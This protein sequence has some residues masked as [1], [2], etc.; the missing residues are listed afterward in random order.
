MLKM[1]NIFIGALILSI[2][3]TTLFWGKDIGLSMLLFNVPL[4]WYLIYILEKNNKIENKKAKLL[5]IPIILLS[6]TYLIFNNTFFNTINVLLIPL[7]VLI[8]VMWLYNEDFSIKTIIGKMIQRVLDP[9]AYAGETIGKMRDSIKQRLNMKIDKEKKSRAGKIFTALCIT[10]PL[11]TVVI[12]LLSSADEAFGKMFSDI[13]SSIGDFFAN[14]QISSFVFRIIV[15]ILL[16]I[17]IASFFD[18]IISKYKVQKTEIQ[19][20][21][22]KDNTT[23]KMVLGVLNVIYLLFCIVQI[24]SLLLKDIDNYSEYAR[25]GFFQLMAVSLINLVTILISKR[26]ENKEDIKSS[27]YINI[28]C[29]IMVLFTFVIIVSS[30][31]RMFFYESAYGYTFLR[32]LVY[33]VLITE[34]ILLIPTCYFILDKKVQLAKV[35]F[36]IIMTMYVCMNFANFDNI[37]AKRNVDRY[38]ET[39]KIDMM[40]LMEDTGTDAVRQIKRLT[41]ANIGEN[42]DEDQKMA[43]DYLTQMYKDLENK[44]MDFRD[45]NISKALAK[46]LIERVNI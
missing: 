18:N 37:I 45:F 35:Y 32:L 44:K 29:I 21:K 33:C 46:Y 6:S 19:E 30:A 11:A 5:L 26:S 24:K 7:L 42:M 10:V 41:Q 27:K 43:K 3:C 2:W 34:S 31:V 23:V 36:V 12:L 40:Y 14:L 9:L 17:Y 15:T 22:V 4:T 16:F 38:I 13:F 39:G 28:M 1:S 20:R 25:Q 8:M